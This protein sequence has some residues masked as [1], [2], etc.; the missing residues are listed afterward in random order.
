MPLFLS[1]GTLAANLFHAGVIRIKEGVVGRV[2][3]P[4]G[5]DPPSPS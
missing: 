3:G 1:A 4:E 5:V 2:D